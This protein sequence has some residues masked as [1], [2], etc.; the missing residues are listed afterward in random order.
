MSTPIATHDTAAEAD[1]AER[2]KKA[3]RVALVLL[4]QYPMIL[5]LVILLVV[6]TFAYPNFWSTDNLLNVVTQ[7]VGLALCCCGMTYVI[8]CGGF[9]LSVGSVFAAGAMVYISCLDHLPVELAVVLSILIGG[10]CGLLN[11]IIINVLKVNTFVATLGSASVFIGLITLYAGSN[12]AFATS[13]DYTYLGTA[14]FAGFPVSGWI[15]LVV[16]LISGIVLARTTFGRAVYAIGGNHEAARLSGLRV[17]AVST[18]TF[19]VIGVLAALGGV[20][21]ASQLG[22]ATPSFVGNITLNSIAIV[23]I[24]GT[25]LT[26][27]E[28]AIWRTMVGLA[29]IAVLNN[30]FTSLNFQ[31]ELQTVFQGAIVIFAVAMEVWLLRR[32][33]S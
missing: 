29:I 32:R 17:G 20:F 31:A 33:K 18:A 24:G 12:A 15:V 4:T 8:I 28:G 10:L 7:N 23:I 2:R 30:L 25:A 27:G 22:T 21:T 13:S 9:D 1:S 6:T 11:G 3:G 19:V 16:I 14:K 26:G 5:A